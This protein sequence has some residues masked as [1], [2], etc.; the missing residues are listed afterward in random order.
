MYSYGGPCIAVEGPIGIFITMYWCVWLCILFLLA[1]LYLGTSNHYMIT[2]LSTY[3]G[4]CLVADQK[5][6]GLWERDWPVPFHQIFRKSNGT[7]SFRKLGPPRSRG[8]PFFSKFGNSE[9]FLFHL[10]CISTRYESAP[11]LLV[12]GGELFELTLPWM[13]NDLLQFEPF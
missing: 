13:Q 9:N 11:V 6:R 4:L 5:A 10:F 3:P 7:E 2:T 1:S 8:C 12:D